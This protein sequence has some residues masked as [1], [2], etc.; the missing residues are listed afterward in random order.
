MRRGSWD[1]D[2]RIHDMD[3]NGVYAS[4]N[5][6]SFVA[7]FGGGRLQTIISDQEL[8]LAT[9]RAYND[10]HIEEWAGRYPDRLI[11]NQITWLHDPEIGAAEIR[12]NAERGFRALTFPETPH[13]LGFPTIFDPYWEPI[14]RACAETDTVLCLHV[15]SG[16]TL[17]PATPGAPSQVTQV[18]FGVWCMTSAIDWLF[19]GWPS[20]YADLKICLSEGGIGWIPAVLD[21]ISAIQRESY[22]VAAVADWDATPR[23]VFLR[24]FNFCFLE[25]RIGLKVIGEIGIDSVMF[26]VDYPHGDSNWPDSQEIIDG[27]IKSLPVNIQQNVTW[28]NASRL[29]RHPVPE[30]VQMDP[31]SF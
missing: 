19:S 7:G 15:G 3:L 23:E 1:V 31:N 8:A 29:F 16:G 11:P 12:R 25:D 13:T 30:A 17:P 27:Q 9:V 24:N 22:R 10:W 5:F 28:K 14:M 6:P 26:E 2:A 18:L 4:L 20:K 21:R